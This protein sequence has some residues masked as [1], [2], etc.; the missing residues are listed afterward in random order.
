MYAVRPW[1]IR[2]TLA[3]RRNQ[4][5]LQRRRPERAGRIGGGATCAPDMTRPPSCDP[6]G[7]GQGWWRL[8][9]G[10]E[11]PVDQIPLDR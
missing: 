9:S 4:R 1:P 3:F 5:V 11:N 6:G 10:H 7:R 8:A 2:G